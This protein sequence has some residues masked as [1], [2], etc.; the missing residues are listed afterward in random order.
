MA[1]DLA[2]ALPTVWSRLVS[3]PRPPSATTSRGGLRRSGPTG[4]GP[5]GGPAW[6]TTPR[7]RTGSPTAPSCPWCAGS[8]TCVGSSAWVRSRSPTGSAC[9]PHRARRVGAVPDQPAP[10]INRHGR[11]HPQLRAREARGSDPCRRQETRQGPRRR[12]VALR[13]PPPR[14]KNRAATPDK[15]RNKWRNPLIGI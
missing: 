7:V 9:R 3:G 13:R 10:H 5:R 11:A 8:C 1:G 14:E 12:W 2:P 15:P 6:S 4:T